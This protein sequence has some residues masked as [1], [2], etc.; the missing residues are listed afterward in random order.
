MTDSGH[1]RL[2][3]LRSREAPLRERV[4]WVLAAC[5]VVGLCS[6]SLQ[7]LFPGR[8]P[9][10]ADVMLNGGSGLLAAVLLSITTATAPRLQPEIGSR[11]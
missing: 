7:V 3:A 9:S 11:E 5:L 1:A 8:H 10:L 4:F 2:R 6:E